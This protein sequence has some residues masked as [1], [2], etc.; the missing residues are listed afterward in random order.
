MK[1]KQRPFLILPI[2]MKT[3]VK[4]IFI[5]NQE[6]N[7]KKKK[8]CEKTWKGWDGGKMNLSFSDK[9]LLDI[10]RQNTVCVMVVEYLN[11]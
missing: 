9:V 4:C 6:K 2:L 8:R 10:G 3:H 1:P 11:Y 5:F 7:R